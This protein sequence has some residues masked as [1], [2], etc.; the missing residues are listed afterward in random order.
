MTTVERPHLG[1]HTLSWGS[2]RTWLAH[3]EEHKRG[4]FN[5]DHYAEHRAGRHAG[6]RAPE[7]EDEYDGAEDE[8]AQP[9]PEPGESAPED[10]PPS[11]WESLRGAA[12][13]VAIWCAGA[14]VVVVLFDP[15]LWLLALVLGALCGALQLQRAAHQRDVEVLAN[16]IAQE[17]ADLEGQR[18]RKQRREE[19]KAAWAAEREAQFEEARLAR[20]A[21]KA[22]NR[23]EGG[24]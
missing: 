8:P 18:R 22:A 24:S 14:L 12:R 1:W 15:A 9:A 19:N 17:R 23:G 11:R 10:A 16:Q 5:D 6:H 3:R 13:D 20:E 7:F 2:A 21:R 4:E